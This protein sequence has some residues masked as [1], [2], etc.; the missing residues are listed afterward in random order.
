MVVAL[1]RPFLATQA[2]THTDGTQ[3]VLGLIIT[4]DSTQDLEGRVT[5]LPAWITI[6]VII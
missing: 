5:G 1:Q 6:K 2:I 3:E 4:S